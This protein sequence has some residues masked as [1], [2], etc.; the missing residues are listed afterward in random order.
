VLLHGVK[1]MIK[2]KYD[3]DNYLF[4]AENLKDAVRVLEDNGFKNIIVNKI[5]RLD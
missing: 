5:T 1:S 2:I 4:Y 3:Y